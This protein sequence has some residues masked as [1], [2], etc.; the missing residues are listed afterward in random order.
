MGI[1][2]EPYIVQLIKKTGAVREF[3]TKTIST[4]ILKKIIDAGIWGFSILG[5]QP[6]YFLLITDKGVIRNL[7]NIILAKSKK[8]PRPF[9]AI[10]ALTAKSLASGAAIIAIY[11]KKT[12]SSRLAK[13]GR[14]YYK[15][16][17]IAELQTIGGAIQNMYL[18]AVSFGL[19]C[20][21]VDS[22]TFFEKEINKILGEDKE[23]LAFLF[24]GYPRSGI[25]TK[26]SPRTLD[27]NSIRKI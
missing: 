2:K 4:C 15:R 6:W 8:Y 25:V 12:V 17:Y 23:L 21:W 16:A 11:N 13:Y 26:R 3:T 18:T 10:L 7:H 22:P 1:K 20:V 14:K 19:G 24:I 5:M 9:D 27:T